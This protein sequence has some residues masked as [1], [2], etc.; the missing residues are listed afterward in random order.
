[1][2]TGWRISTAAMSTAKNSL[3]VFAYRTG[4]DSPASSHAATSSTL[5]KDDSQEQ[6]PLSIRTRVLLTPIRTRP[7]L[8]ASVP[9]INCSVGVRSLLK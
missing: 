6:M 8:L 2:R 7:A 9:H 3:S 5:K 1:M 4:F